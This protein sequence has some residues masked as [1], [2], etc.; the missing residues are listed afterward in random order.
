MRLFKKDFFSGSKQTVKLTRCFLSLLRT[1][2]CSL[3]RIGH[4]VGWKYQNVVATLEMR[5]KAKSR[6]LYAKKEKEL[7]VRKQAKVELQPKIKKY[8]KV[9]KSYGYQY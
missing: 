9:I 4:E 3:G 1:Q 5:R 8:Q 7:K 2:Y 6:I